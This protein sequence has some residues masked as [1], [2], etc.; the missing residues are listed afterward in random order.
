[1]IDKHNQAIEE[2]I[3]DVLSLPGTE[4]QDKKSMTFF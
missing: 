3:D 2:S 1:M 4:V